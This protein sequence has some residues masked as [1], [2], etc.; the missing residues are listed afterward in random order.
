[1]SQHI[2][3]QLSNAHNMLR[4][5]MLRYVALA[6]CDRL[7]GALYLI[8]PCW[9]YRASLVEQWFMFTLAQGVLSDSEN[10]GIFAVNLVSLFKRNHCFSEF[11]RT[12]ITALHAVRLQVISCYY[13]WS[14]NVS[15]VYSKYFEIFLP[16]MFCR[17]SS[18]MVTSSLGCDPAAP[19]SHT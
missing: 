15:V 2:A 9:V 11:Q 17:V 5:T 19:R 12:Q 14:L 3:T 8:V 16:V 4:P 7:A 6:C 1:M 13:L 18:V 10:I